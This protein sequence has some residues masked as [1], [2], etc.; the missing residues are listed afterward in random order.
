MYATWDVYTL[1][2]CYI[3]YNNLFP[4]PVVWYWHEII[5]YVV[6]KPGRAVSEEQI[7]IANGT[8]PSSIFDQRVITLENIN[9]DTDEWSEPGLFYQRTVG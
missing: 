7:C 8:R 1:R 5:I 2:V 3:R 4:Y 6:F 9:T